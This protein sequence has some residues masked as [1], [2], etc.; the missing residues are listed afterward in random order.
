MKVGD[1]VRKGQAVGVMGNTGNCTSSN[2]NVPKIYAGTHL[3]LEVHVNGVPTDPEPFLT[4][5]KSI[6]LPAISSVA[7]LSQPQSP[8]SFK[9]GDKVK[10]MNAVQLNGRPFKTYYPF[11]EVFQVRRDGAVVIRFFQFVE[12]H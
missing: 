3:H 8:A 9:A 2:P 5:A 6:G 1:V 12:N 4:G 10:V 7:A 11:Y